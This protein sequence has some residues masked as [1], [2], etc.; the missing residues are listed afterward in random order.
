MNL[1]AIIGLIASVGLIGMG[2]LLGSPFFVFFDVTAVLIVVIGTFFMLLCSGMGRWLAGGSL[3]PWGAHECRKTS[4]VAHSGG[5]LAIAMGGLGCLIGLVSM[6]R[7]MDDPS[8]IGPA[9]AVTLLATF[10]AALMNLLFFVPMSRHFAEA[11]LD[12]EADGVTTV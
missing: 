5:I 7:N 1:G 12:A 10:Y 3:S 6:L 9:M 8:N 4:H 2:I 11:A